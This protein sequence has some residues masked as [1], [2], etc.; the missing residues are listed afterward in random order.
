MEPVA[1]VDQSGISYLHSDHLYTTRLATNDL[2]ET[3]WRWES[4][5][6]GNTEPQIEQIEVNLRFPGQYEDDES[7][8]YYNWKRYYDPQLGRYVSSDPIGLSGGYNTYA[9]ASGN[10]LRFFDPYGLIDSTPNPVPNNGSLRDSSR[11]DRPGAPGSG[12]HINPKVARMER[13]L[14]RGRGFAGALGSLL[15][16]PPGVAEF[17]GGAPKGI[18]G[19]ALLG[20]PLLIYPSELGVH[21]CEAPGGPPCYPDEWPSEEEPIMPPEEFIPEEPIPEEPC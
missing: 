21:P 9:Y 17:I 5:A 19:A 11:L 6:F 2:Q 16:L 13:N 18:G 10:P 8:L 4:G 1:Q 20:I 15:G 3:V 7:G 12:P 14:R